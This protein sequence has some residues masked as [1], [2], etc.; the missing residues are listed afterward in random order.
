MKRTATRRAG[1]AAPSRGPRWSSNVVLLGDA[2]GAPAS[3]TCGV[4]DRANCIDD[5]ECT[6]AFGGG[7]PFTI[8]GVPLAK[9]VA[10]LEAGVETRLRPNLM[11]GASYS[12]QFGDGL[13]DHGF[14][15]NLNWTF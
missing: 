9:N 8:A 2:A 11:L 12:G 13:R 10:V 6:L 5:F 7:L 15:A 3:T 1:A 4:V 14:K